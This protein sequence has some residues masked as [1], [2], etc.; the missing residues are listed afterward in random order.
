MWLCNSRRVG[1]ARCLVKKNTRHKYILIKSVRSLEWRRAGMCCSTPVGQYSLIEKPFLF[2]F[3]H[4]FHD[5][6]YNIP[7][8]TNHATAAHRTVKK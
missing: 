4:G 7:P 3:L 8:L 6:Y 2:I 5:T 1:R